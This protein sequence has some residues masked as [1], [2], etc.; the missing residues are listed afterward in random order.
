[1]LSSF[2][3]GVLHPF[4]PLNEPNDPHRPKRVQGVA[5]AV[6]ARIDPSAG[7]P[8][9]EREKRE[10]MALWGNSPA[11][12][13]GRETHGGS[14]NQRAIATIAANNEWRIISI[15]WPI[16]PRDARRL[17]CVPFVR[18]ARFFLFIRQDWSR[19]GGCIRGRLL[20]SLAFAYLAREGGRNGNE[21]FYHLFKE[22]FSTVSF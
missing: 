8:P 3:P 12:R 2:G 22:L 1:L 6:A 21:Q 18:F 14:I 7:A 13:R 10:H 9:R 20:S 11:G 16:D 15:T 17:E 5:A 19:D 4:H